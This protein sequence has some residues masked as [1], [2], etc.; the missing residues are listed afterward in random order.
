M[1]SPQMPSWSRSRS[2]A[3]TSDR[4]PGGRWLASAIVRPSAALRADDA[5]YV[6]GSC[7][8]RRGRPPR[9]RRPAPSARHP[10]G[11]SARKDLVREILRLEEV[12]VTRVAPDTWRSRSPR[13]A[14]LNELPLRS[15]AGG[16]ALAAFS[17]TKY[18]TAPCPPPAPPRK[19]ST[20]RPC[21]PAS[22]A[23]RSTATPPRT[24]TP[25]S[26]TRSRWPV[27]GRAAA[28]TTRPARSA[29]RAGRRTCGR[30][31][32]PARARSTSRRSCTRVRRPRASTTRRRTPRRHRRA[33]RTTRA[34]LHEH[35]DRCRRRR[36]H[37]RPPRPARLDRARRRAA[38]GLPARRRDE[39]AVIA[40]TPVDLESARTSI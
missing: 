14:P 16:K 17:S 35:G 27:A 9:F 12:G 1:T 39:G 7:G 33:R 10:L 29:R 23:R 5:R 36:D 32:W 31:R 26:P 11:Q 38:P 3:R 19:P 4:A 20:T 6:R 24:S 37:D 21:W 28:G 13:H 15:S 22:G 25:G 18:S 30:R 8:R 34:A 40:S 2:R